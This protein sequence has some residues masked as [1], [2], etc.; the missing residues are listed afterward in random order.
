MKSKKIVSRHI[1]TQ[2]DSGV[3]RSEFAKALG[4]ERSNFVT[5]LAGD[6]YPEALLPASRLPQFAQVCGLTDREALMLTEARIDDSPDGTITINRETLHFLQKA[7]HRFAT[8]ELAGRA[9]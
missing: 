2:L 9:H 4:F 5:M 7:F 3:T 1:R 6:N 8:A